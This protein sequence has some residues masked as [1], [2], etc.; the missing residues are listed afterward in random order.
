MAGTHVY[1]GH[2][3][4][5]AGTHVYGGHSCVWRAF[6]RNRATAPEEGEGERCRLEPWLVG[7]NSRPRGPTRSRNRHIPNLT[8]GGSRRSYHC[9]SATPKRNQS[10][11]RSRRRLPE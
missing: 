6:K 3:V 8:R 4:C 7:S 10:D 2:S 5:M 1:G 11:R 9:H